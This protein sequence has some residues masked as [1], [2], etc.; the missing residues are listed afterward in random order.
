MP[1]DAATICAG[2]IGHP[3]R[4][5]GQADVPPAV[6]R[7]V[8]PLRAGPAVAPH[9]R[10]VSRAGVR[11]D[12]A[13]DAGGARPAEVSRVVGAV[14]VAPGA[15]LVDRSRRGRGVV[16]ARVQRPAAA[17]SRDRPRVVGAL[18]RS[19]A[20]RCRGVAQLQ[21]DWPVH[22]GRD[23]E[24]R[25]RGAGADPRHERGARAVPR[26]RGARRREIPRGS[27]RA[28]ADLGVPAARAARL[29]LQ[30]GAD[31]LRRPRV[32][33]PQAPLSACPLARICR[34]FPAARPAR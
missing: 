16:P 32:R 4:R 26:V 1:G 12:A 25:V 13:A 2:G 20:A 19:P 28:V 23:H 6:A 11:G 7:L 3:G 15:C 27:L 29:R 17:S 5:R 18:R 21:G 33:R 22:G 24:L 30:P 14:P 8:R 10:S 31:G 34:T 9:A